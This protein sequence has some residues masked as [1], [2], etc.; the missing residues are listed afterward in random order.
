MRTV[1]CDR[2]LDSELHTQQHPQVFMQCHGLKK[3]NIFILTNLNC[4]NQLFSFKMNEID[5]MWKIKD[6][7]F[8]HKTNGNN[9]ELKSEW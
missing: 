3:E 7:I 2:V 6:R 1:K 4:A 8:K 5:C 9:N